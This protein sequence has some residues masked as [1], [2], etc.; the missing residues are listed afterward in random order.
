MKKTEK[1][2][3]FIKLKKINQKIFNL[4][5]SNVGMK[6]NWSSCFIPELAW[7]LRGESGN[8]YN[9]TR[10]SIITITDMNTAKTISRALAYSSSYFDCQKDFIH[11]ELELCG[12]YMSK[13]NP[14][15]SLSCALGA[16]TSS[17]FGNTNLELI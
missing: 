4:Q 17:K 6:N 16:M 3:D 5:D 11:F 1:L 8:S 12:L 2:S 7:L 9:R 15:I 14:I 13:L 10:M